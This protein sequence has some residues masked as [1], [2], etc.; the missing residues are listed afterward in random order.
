MADK[1]QTADSTPKCIHCQTEMKKTAIPREANFEAPFFYVCFNNECSYFIEGWEWMSNKYKVNS[2]YRYRID[3][4]TD[5]DGP[6]PV[7]SK[8]AMRDRII[9]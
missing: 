3:P 7:W 6:F 9:E 1:D 4:A 5:K 8:D 2:S